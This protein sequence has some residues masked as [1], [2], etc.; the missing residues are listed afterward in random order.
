MKV[1]I[2]FEI[3][4]AQILLS[5]LRS[6]TANLESAIKTIEPYGKGKEFFRKMC[7]SRLAFGRMAGALDQALEQPPSAVV[8]KMCEPQ[9]SQNINR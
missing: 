4:D 1:Q 2:E 5:R 7:E 8:S 3:E 6:M 9:C